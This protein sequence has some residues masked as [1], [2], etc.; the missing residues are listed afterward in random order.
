MVLKCRSWAMEYYQVSPEECRKR[1]Q[2][3]ISVGY[4]LIDWHQPIIMKKV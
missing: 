3:A 2:E 1:C 4:R